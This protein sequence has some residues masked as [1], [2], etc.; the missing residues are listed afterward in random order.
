MNTKRNLR[1][2]HVQS[3]CTDRMNRR[4]EGVFVV[5]I[6]VDDLVDQMERASNNVGRRSCEG[7]LIVDYQPTPN[8]AQAKWIAD[9]PGE[10]KMPIEEIV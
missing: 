4:I 8:P 9:H 10:C 7:A 5:Y 2:I 6:D 3:G 1:R